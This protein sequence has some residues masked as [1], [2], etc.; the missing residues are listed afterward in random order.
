MRDHHKMRICS[1][2]EETEFKPGPKDRSSNLFMIN[3]LINKHQLQ[4]QLPLSICYKIMITLSN[5][6]NRKESTLF[7]FAHTARFKNCLN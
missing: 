2:F 5:C 3:V 6:N 7:L 4:L 1:L